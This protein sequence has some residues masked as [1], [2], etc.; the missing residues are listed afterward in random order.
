LEG[1]NLNGHSLLRNLRQTDLLIIWFVAFL[2]FIDLFSPRPISDA[3]QL[4]FLNVLGGALIVVLAN[5]A[6]R[7]N[8]FRIAHDWYPAPVIFLTYKE[9]YVIMQSLHLK[10]HDAFLISV[11]RAIFGADP[12]AFLSHIA[13]PVLTEILQIAYASYFIIMITVGT[14]LYIKNRRGDFSFYLFTIMFGFFLSYIGYL[15]LPAV[16]PRFTLHNFADTNKE[17]PGLWLAIPIRDFLNAGESIPKGVADA[18]K[19]AQRDVFPS[20]HTEMTLIALFFATKFKLKS[21]PYLYVAGALLICATVYL[22]YHYV[23]DLF[24]G[25][26]T[27]LL[28]VLTAPL[29][30]KRWDLA[31]VDAVIPVETLEG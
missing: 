30:Y 1:L 19:Y 3:W 25:A 20:G 9:I 31:K 5:L 18:V 2:T 7:S 11:D 23:V 24:G 28:A 29:I 16:G 15:L 4:I 27:M 14:E 10:D 26:L 6:P 22:R 21:R 8:I 17:L 13:T 12:T